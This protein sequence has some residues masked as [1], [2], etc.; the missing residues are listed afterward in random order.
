[1]VGK[2][3]GEEE[4]LGILGEISGEVSDEKYAIAIKST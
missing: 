1:M 4:C 3:R 2:A